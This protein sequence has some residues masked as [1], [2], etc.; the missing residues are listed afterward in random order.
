[1]T[2]N[3]E[4]PSCQFCGVLQSHGHFDWCKRTRA[5]T[6]VEVLEALVAEEAHC[7]GEEGPTQGLTDMAKAALAAVK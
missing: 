6:P 1:M 3:V 4:E 5:P 2:D 7:V